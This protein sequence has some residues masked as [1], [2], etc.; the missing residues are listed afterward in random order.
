MTRVGLN[1]KTIDQVPLDDQTVLVR[2]DYNV[3]LTTD[4]QIA[5]DYRMRMSLPT[6]KSLVGRGCRVVV[7]AHLGRP[8]GKAEAKYS[9]EPVAH[10]LVELLDQPVKFVSDCVGDKA[11]QASRR[12]KKGEVLLLENLRFH[13]GEESN[14]RNFARDLAKASRARYFVQDGFG[15]VHR[16]HASTAAITEFLPSVAGKLLEKEVNTITKAMEQPKRPLVAV[17]GGAKI[18]DKIGLVER[19]VKIA[20]KVVIGGA[21][22][23]TF[24]A[25]KG[26]DIGASLSEDGLSDVIEAVYRAT[27][28]KTDKLILPIDVGVGKS[29]DQDE[30]RRDADLD[31]I[32]ADDK[33][34]DIGPKTIEKVAEVIDSAKTVIWNGTLG[35]AELNQFAHGSAR[36]ALELAKRKGGLESIVGGGDTADFVINWDADHGG[37]FSHVSTG[38]GASLELMSGQKLPGVEALLD[39]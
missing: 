22:A 5:D 23:N 32:A 1:K 12:L 20:D 13:P 14:D 18:S 29:T 26:V 24:L 9:L 2:A 11:A 33:I 6:L 7:C 35:Y 30:P 28:G 27:G 21:M 34:L 39:D 37:S 16:A 36:T 25:D 4:G 19:F 38:G 17:L 3:P 15:V 8:D 10:H 31:Q